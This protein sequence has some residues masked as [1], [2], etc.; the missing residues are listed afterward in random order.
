MKE[1]PFIKYHK[2]L[3]AKIVPFAGYNMPVEYS[4]ITDEHINVREKLGVFDVSHMGEFWVLV[5]SHT[6]LFS[7]LLQ[8]MFLNLLMGKFSIHVFPMV[9]EGLLMIYWF[10]GS[11]MRNI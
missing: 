2:E 10:T 1:T 8:M 11:V 9:K 6:C 7:I 3:G 5:Q 4:G